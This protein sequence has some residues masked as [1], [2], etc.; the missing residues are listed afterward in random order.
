MSFTFLKTDLSHVFRVNDTCIILNV[1]QKV[2]F[3]CESY[4]FFYQTKSVL[5]FASLRVW[6]IFVGD[7]PPLPHLP[8]SQSRSSCRSPRPTDRP[9]PDRTSLLSC[10]FLPS[11]SLDR[12]VVVVVVVVCEKAVAS[13]ERGGAAVAFVVAVAS[14]TKE[15]ELGVVWSCFQLKYFYPYNCV[16]SIT[17]TKSLLPAQM[18]CK[19]I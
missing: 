18:N 4:S 8:P 14:D 3:P 12:F 2:I 7:R 1:S 17:S 6:D 19:A 11:F 5:N 10:L 15:G 13:R 9:R 16:V